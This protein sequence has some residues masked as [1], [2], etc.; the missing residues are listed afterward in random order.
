[1]I[2]RLVGGVFLCSHQQL[3]PDRVGRGHGKPEEAAPFRPT[4]AP[5]DAYTKQNKTKQNKH[6]NLLSEMYIHAMESSRYQRLGAGAGAEMQGDCGCVLSQREGDWL[7]AKQ[8]GREPCKHTHTCTR[9]KQFVRL[10]TR[11]YLGKFRMLIR[12]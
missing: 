4:A 6:S 10:L 11:A 7:E 12:N 2:W 3:E 8:R 1:M 9:S 5:D